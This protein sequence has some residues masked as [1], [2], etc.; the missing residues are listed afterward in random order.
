MC[1][2]LFCSKALLICTG[3]R[4]KANLK[5]GKIVLDILESSAIITL[6]LKVC[7]SAGTGRQARLRGVCQPTWEFKSPLSHQCRKLKSLRHFFRVWWE[8]Y[9]WHFWKVMYTIGSCKRNITAVFRYRFSHRW[10]DMWQLCANVPR[11]RTLQTKPVYQKQRFPGF[12]TVSSISC[13]I[14][15]ASCRERV[16]S[17]V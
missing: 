8:C 7:E 3:R 9:C 17:P 15:R 5:F 12:L 2:V 4:W 13:Q 14:G 1:T 10:K 11:Y 16:S 6:A